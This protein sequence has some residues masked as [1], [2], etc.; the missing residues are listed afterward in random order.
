MSQKS[1]IITILL[2]LSLVTT[3]LHAKVTNEKE[4]QKTPLSLNSVAKSLGGAVNGVGKAIGRT[5][6]G[7]G[8]TLG[9]TINGVGE[10]AEGTVRFATNVAVVGGIVVGCMFL[11]YQVWELSD[12]MF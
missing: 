3:E 8:K 10:F 11:D 12:M 9:R 4:K 5:T 1:I 2:C 7:V 6:N